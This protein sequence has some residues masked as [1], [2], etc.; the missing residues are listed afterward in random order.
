MRLDALDE[1]AALGAVARVAIAAMHDPHRSRVGLNRLV[2]RFVIGRHDFAKTMAHLIVHV[3]QQCA[4]RIEMH[5]IE[6]SSEHFTNL[7]NHCHFNTS[8][9]KTSLYQLHS[10]R[11]AK[12]I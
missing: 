1:T 2:E 9:P 11:K 5:S 7:I 12:F 10:I 4:T 6:I 3:V 8:N